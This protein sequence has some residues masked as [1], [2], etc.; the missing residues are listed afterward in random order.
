MFF[1]SL[2]QLLIVIGAFICFNSHTAEAF[3][4]WSIISP[5]SFYF[6]HINVVGHG[7]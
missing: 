6:P 4:G 7:Q 1:S 2:V 3:I 5:F